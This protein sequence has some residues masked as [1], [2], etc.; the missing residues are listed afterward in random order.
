MTICLAAI[1]EKGD[2][3]IMASDSM[4]T[5]PSL[6][7]EFEIKSP[8]LEE[9]CENCAIATAGDALVHTELVEETALTINHMKSPTVTQ[10]V[11]SIKKS[12][13]TLRQRKI[14]ETILQPK[15]FESM[16]DFYDRQ[17]HILPEIAMTIQRAIDR[18]DYGLEI[19][20]GGVDTRAHI[21][22]V[23][24]PGTSAPFDSL[25][26]AAI[27]SGYPHA[28]TSFIANEYH[29]DFPL[30]RALL[31]AYEAKKISE[32]APGVGSN[33]T[34][35]CVIS[36]NAVRMLTDADIKKLDQVYRGKIE[37][38]TKLLQGRDWAKEL[39]GM[40]ND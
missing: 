25:G 10:V 18:Y 31:V 27:G 24:N 4:L 7:I 23:V 16:A 39:G 38:Q 5:S 21:H 36:K 15:G 8:K 17:R 28:T 40:L 12:Y 32:K 3:V 19:L 6:S 30:G 26:H 13:A 1:C 9:L 33:L 14:V 34:N 11:D 35:M 29:Q 20:V 22:A 2:K 37:E